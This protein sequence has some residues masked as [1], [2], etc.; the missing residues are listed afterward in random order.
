M[1]ETK[2]SIQETI[3]DNS[4]Y[5]EVVYDQ[6]PHKQGNLR[7]L[8]TIGDLYGV[9]PADIYHCRVLEI[10]TA[11]GKTIIPQAEE[12][13]ESQ[14][15]GI[16]LSPVQIDVGKELLRSL[17]L[18]NIELRAANIMDVDESWGEFD[19]IIAHG[20]YSWV[21]PVVQEKML[22]ILQTNLS[23]HG[24]AMYSY[25]TYPGWRFKEVSREL[26]L[27]H[28]RQA[29]EF[30]PKTEIQEARAVIDFT[31]EFAAGRKDYFANF[32]ASTQDHLKKVTDHYLAH[33]HLEVYNAPCYFSEF[34]RR[35]QE[36]NLRY[37]ADCDWTTHYKLKRNEKLLQLFK[38]E[39]DDETLEQYCDFLTN[40]TFRSS[41]ICRRDINVQ[42][43]ESDI[44]NR[45]H[46][47]MPADCTIKSVKADEVN[48]GSPAGWHFET[49]TCGKIVS[50]N[51][52]IDL[53]FEYFINNQ[54]GF[55]TTNDLW[56]AVAPQL[57]DTG[58]QNASL[59]ALGT[60]FSGLVQDGEIRIV[61][62]PPTDRTCDPRRPYVRT[63]VRQMLKRNA[64]RLPNTMFESI[65]IDAFQAKLMKQF[66][67]RRSI[68]EHVSEVQKD[69]LKGRLNVTYKGAAIR[70]DDRD[71][72]T[73]S[74]EE[75]VQSL[76]QRRLVF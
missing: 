26:M 60:L 7:L 3:Q 6:L 68:T 55:F 43:R 50:S 54:E 44:L 37:V 2:D 45:Y 18:R 66:D 19:Y 74:V 12:F 62:R 47:F 63:F 51:P 76:R 69:M 15:L 16:D 4:S 35:L 22:D 64:T 38:K 14:F 61:L 1:T 13:P 36:K 30:D 32:F 31:T 58:D 48:E 72:I 5:D 42:L 53:V 70:A 11:T 40:R 46:F 17:N 23:P 59:S 21:P 49:A 27:F 41:V 34:C 57:Q 75:V 25:N 29:H 9:E 52:L 39:Q 67:G 20:I 28:A 8:E 33:E 65:G 10:G 24:L 73:K 56:Q 71:R